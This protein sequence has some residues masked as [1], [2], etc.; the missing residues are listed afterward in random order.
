MSYKLTKPSS[1]FL[2]SVCLSCSVQFSYSVISDS[3]EIPN[4]VIG[5]HKKKNDNSLEEEGNGNP[6]QCPCLENPRD[7]GAWWAAVC[8]I[9]QSQTRLMWLSS[10]SSRG[11]WYLFCFQL[12]VTWIFRTTTSFLLAILVS[13]LVLTPQNPIIPVVFMSSHLKNINSCCNFLP[14]VKKH[15]KNLKIW[16]LLS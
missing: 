13:P 4:E 12:Q 2:S 9:A 11:H 16:G 10:S 14:T 6:L 8:G 1:G 7:R 3:A 15:H 5:T